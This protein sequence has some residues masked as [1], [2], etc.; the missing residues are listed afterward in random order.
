MTVYRYYRVIGAAI[1]ALILSTPLT[2]ATGV[3][4]QEELIPLDQQR[5]KLNSHAAQEATNYVGKNVDISFWSTPNTLKLD[6]SFLFLEAL[7]IRFQE[8][9]AVTFR[10]FPYVV[11]G[12][13]IGCRPQQGKAKISD[14]CRSR[15]SNNGRYCAYGDTSGTGVNGTQ[16]IRETVRRMCYWNLYGVNQPENYL[17][18]LHQL[19][20]Q[21]CFQRMTEDCI[22][23]AMS[24]MNVQVSQVDDCMKKAGKL[25]PGIDAKNSLL[26]VAIE[27]SKIVDVHSPNDFSI[28]QVVGPV[29]S[30][31]DM[32]FNPFPTF[33][34][35]FCGAFPE[36]NRPLICDFCGNFCPK[37]GWSSN[38]H[39]NVKNCISELQCGDGRTFENWVHGG[40]KDNNSSRLKRWFAEKRWEEFD[41]MLVGLVAGSSFGVLLACFFVLRTWKSQRR[42]NRYLREREAE[43]EMTG[44]A[45]DSY[46]DDED[47]SNFGWPEQID[48][49]MDPSMQ[50]NDY[51]GNGR[52]AR[53]GPLEQPPRDLFPPR[54]T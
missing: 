32:H 40:Y 16:V 37:N 8:T 47:H 20:D 33:Q 53:T 43:R 10:P 5:R 27:A 6:E 34:E 49:D 38:K 25:G 52:Q 21:G 39:Y 15:C 51:V 30:S 3:A 29:K 17:Q 4:Q 12:A 1:I 28:L 41:F 48:L 50:Y 42:I 36:S 13:T 18:Y 11:D 2:V 22:V 54:L 26:E 23:E 46:N 45:H 14:N 24:E 7:L 44:L 31:T 9:Q 19:D 35:S